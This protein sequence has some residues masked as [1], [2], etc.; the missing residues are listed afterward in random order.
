MRMRMR[1]TEMRNDYED[2]ENENEDDENESAGHIHLPDGTDADESRPPFVVLPPSYRDLDGSP[3]CGHIFGRAQGYTRMFGI[4][5][6][7]SITAWPTRDG[8]DCLSLFEACAG[9]VYDKITGTVPRDQ[10]GVTWR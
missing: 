2:E 3:E 6:G 1:T 5:N 8:V 4:V 7:T 10:I 9:T